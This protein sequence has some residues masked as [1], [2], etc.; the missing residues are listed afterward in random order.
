MVEVNQIKTIKKPYFLQCDMKCV[1]AYI[2][3]ITAL[4]NY[5]KFSG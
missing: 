2:F 3:F 4:T 5:D 1:H